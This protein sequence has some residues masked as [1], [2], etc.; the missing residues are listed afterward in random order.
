M[1]IS[2]FGAYDCSRDPIKTRRSGEKAGLALEFS[3]AV[4]PARWSACLSG[5]RNRWKHAVTFHRN[6]KAKKSLFANSCAPERPRR[7][8][9]PI[10]SGPLAFSE[11]LTWDP[12]RA[13]CTHYWLVVPLQLS[14]LGFMLVQYMLVTFCLAAVSVPFCVTEQLFCRCSWRLGTAAGS[15]RST[16]L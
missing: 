8:S 3:P 4:P 9:S 16:M 1:Y 15:S 6:P 5:A 14:I 11:Q 13:V 10:A 2:F 12:S 7:P